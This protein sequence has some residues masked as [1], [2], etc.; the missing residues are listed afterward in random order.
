MSDVRHSQ[1]FGA[2]GSF[3][4]KKM[5]ALCEEASGFVVAALL[6]RKHEKLL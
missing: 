2:W 3:F 1:I 6:E 4:E 5:K